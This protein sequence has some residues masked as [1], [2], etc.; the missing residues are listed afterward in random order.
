MKTE[1]L[2]DL[3]RQHSEALTKAE[4]LPRGSAERAQVEREAEFI[5]VRIN[6]WHERANP[7]P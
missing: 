7:A 3:E 2:K 6:D 4:A 5:T 1:N